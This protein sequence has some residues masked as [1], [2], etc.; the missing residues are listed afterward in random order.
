MIDIDSIVAE[1]KSWK[2]KRKV[3]KWADDNPELAGQ[4]YEL[5]DSLEDEGLPLYPSMDLFVEAAGGP[6]GHPNTVR[7]F[8]N[9]RRWKL[10][11]ANS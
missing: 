2:R 9:E 6:P 1:A 3:D 10:S 11:R 4:L 7:A 8:I 5:A